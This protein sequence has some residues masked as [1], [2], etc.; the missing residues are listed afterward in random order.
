MERLIAWVKTWNWPLY[1]RIQKWWLRTGLIAIPFGIVYASTV[2]VLG[3]ESKVALVAVLIA[4]LV[5][6]YLIQGMPPE[7]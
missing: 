4:A 6:N 1:W 7:E 3:H 2:R 5:T